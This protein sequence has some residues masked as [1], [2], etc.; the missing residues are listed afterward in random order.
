[1][2]WFVLLALIVLVA[3][4]MAEAQKPKPETVITVHAKK[5][6]FVPGQIT[7][8]VGQPVR[9][10]FVSED[11]PH[12]IAVDELAIDLPITKK[13]SSILITPQKV[14][15]LTGMCS[16][17]CGAGHDEMRLTIHVVP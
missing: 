14:A 6:A 7:I 16:R 17:Y 8:H 2:Q 11:V 4:G 1:M 9:L 3:A 12:A 13:P 15:E 10:F 5:Y